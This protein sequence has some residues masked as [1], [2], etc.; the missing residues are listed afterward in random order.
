M[1]AALAGLAAT[2]FAGAAWAQ[3]LPVANPAAIAH[4]ERWPVA[5]SPW[6]GNVALER[7]VHALLARMSLEDKVGQLVQIDIDTVKP[8][9]LRQYKIGAILDGGNSKPGQ[10]Q[11]AAPV[12]WLKLADAFWDNNAVRSDGRPVIPLIWG[13]DAVHGDNDVIGATLF[14]QNI[15]LGNARDPELIR[16]IGAA[17]AAEVA[18][19]GLDWSFAPTLAVVQDDRWGRTYESYSEE[20]SVVASYAGAMVE[21]LQG[22]HGTRAFM[23][24]DKVIA[25]P[26]H[27]LGD[28][29]TGGHDQ[30][31]TRV[32]EATLIGVH[33]VGYKPAID[34]GALTVMASYSSWNG[35]KMHG[36]AS[37]LT[38]LLKQRY[39][40]DGFVTGDWKGHGQLPGCTADHCATAIDAGVDQFMNADDWRV[41]YRNTLADAR[42]GA[43]PMARLDDAVRR[44]LRV[45]L[46]AGVFDKGRPSS[47]PL[48]GHFDELGSAEHRA[49][50][51][52]AVRESLVLLKNEGGL[53]PLR[54]S[55][56]VLVAGSGADNI[57]Q[58]SG[59]WTIT[60]QGT[61]LT[62]ADFPHAQSIYAG[63]AE[64]MR[65]G[66]GSAT[67]A[68]EGRYEAKPDAAIVVFG[69][70][71][72][73]E[74]QGD[75]PTLEYAPQDKSDLA[76]LRRLKAAG[77]PVVAVFL[78]G[79]PMWVNAELN[80]SDA[81]VAAFLPGS[82][83]GGVADVLVRRPDGA[84]AH[85]FTGRLA[86]SWPK[87][88]DQYVLNRRDAGYDPLFAFGY[89]LSYAAPGHVAALDET[90]P[91]G[92][93]AEASGVF[94]AK[95]K[96][97][98]GWRFEA[99]KGA[100]MTSVDRRAQEDSRRF[101]WPKRRVGL[102]RLIADEPVD[103]RRETNG[104]LSLVV[105]ARL[106]SAS[107]GFL[108]LTML[109]DGAS[110]QHVGPIR[111]DDALRAAEPGAWTTIAISLHCFAAGSFDVEHIRSPLALFSNGDVDMTISDI[112]IESV[113]QPTM[114]C[115]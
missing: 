77:V 14:P 109:G 19:T 45:K 60:W 107:K 80:A 54:A 92:L 74:F 62:N 102:A 96:L 20:P 55:S 111:I 70:Q 75:R 63:L 34:A 85:D 39:G 87:R 6:A 4:A 76:L 50:A 104:D 72:Y 7:R 88:P 69:E 86:F 49:V 114:R 83:G 22:R 46:L 16:A 1:R 15:G 2:L 78:S 101:M 33:A 27:F 31:D 106:D 10:N 53:L 57:S 108:G 52:R 105:E 93:G 65:A 51:R 25:T 26:K 58:Q 40:F 73:A 8:E 110:T 13:T 12:D 94:F 36:N 3:P 42:S 23:G 100:V 67:L 66:G 95:G 98:A 103:L 28:G 79:R 68:V 41:L 61:G 35:A 97:K 113:A 37:L 21:G 112:R 84:V 43:I 24:P 48:A 17:T 18:A 115:P 32:D 44:V 59:G 5:R 30:G 99:G 56:R 89:G 64:A 81:F 82:E 71:P 29:G 90:R 47:R 38:G 9:E 11:R 91:A